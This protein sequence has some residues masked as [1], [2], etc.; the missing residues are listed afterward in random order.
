PRS[1]LD[2]PDASIRARRLNIWGFVYGASDCGYSRRSPHRSA[3]GGGRLVVGGR[4]LLV[5]ILPK[6]SSTRADASTLSCLRAQ[7]AGGGIDAR[8][9]LLRLLPVQ[10]CGRGGNGSGWAKATLAGGCRG[11]RHWSAAVRNRQQWLGQRRQVPSRGRWCL[12][13]GGGELQC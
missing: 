8:H 12:C 11:R 9:V 6:I 4:L 13:V 5:P 7:R 3:N 2:G 10:S 1:L